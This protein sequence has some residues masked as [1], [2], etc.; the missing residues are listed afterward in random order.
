MHHRKYSITGQADMD[1]IIQK[2]FYCSVAFP[3]TPPY[4]IPMNFGY[5]DGCIYLHGAKKGEKVR[6]LTSHNEGCPVSLL[7]VA[8]ATL[9]A[10]G[11]AACDLTTNHESVII[12]GIAS[13]VTDD[14]EK[15]RGI[16]ALLTHVGKEELPINFTL[17][18]RTLF[19]RVVI[20]EMTG[21][22]RSA[23]S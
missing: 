14:A 2:S 13:E 4:I 5:T 18:K 22:R 21:S 17:L 19:I 1:A 10:T 3:G 7:F 15:S 23:A 12:K 16:K 8:S 6:Y 11:D 9:Y 20:D